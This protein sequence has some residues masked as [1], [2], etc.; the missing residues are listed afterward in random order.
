MEWTICR[1][2]TR[3]DLC[4]GTLDISPLARQLVNPVTIN[5]SV[6][7]FATVRM[8]VLSGGATYRIVSRD[9]KVELNGSFED[10]VNH[11]ELSLVSLILKHYWQEEWPPLEIELQAESPKGA[12]MGGSSSLCVAV[13]GCLSKLRLSLDKKPIF[14]DNYQHAA[15]AQDIE[16]ELICIPTGCQDYWGAV[17]GGANILRY[18][19]GRV[20]VTNLAD[21][22]MSGLTEQILLWYSGVSR[23]SA[24]NNWNVFKAFFDGNRSVQCGLQE[25]ATCS[26]QVADAFLAK[27]WAKVIDASKREWGLRT[28]M[29]PELETNETKSIDDV[30]RAAGAYFTRICGA[31]GGGVMALFVPKDSKRKVIDAL[32]GCSGCLLDASIGVHGISYE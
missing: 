11:N 6:G 9:Q 18:P 22:Q 7:L 19:P 21:F 14:N 20:D 4:G 27:D 32:D 24:E 31:G 30:A 17:C 3:L 25:I 5:L 2:P 10:V 13:L 16:A 26:N 12:G 29:W 28:K 1:V 15:I 23:A 8:R